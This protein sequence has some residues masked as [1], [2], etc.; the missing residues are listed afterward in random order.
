MILKLLA[1]LEHPVAFIA[2]YNLAFPLEA[3]CPSQSQVVVHRQ[4]QGLK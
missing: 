3:N 1:F 4:T 2:D